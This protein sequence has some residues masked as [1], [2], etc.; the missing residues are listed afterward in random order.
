[1]RVQSEIAEM[2]GKRRFDAK[3]FEILALLARLPATLFSISIYNSLSS[4]TTSLDPGQ[5]VSQWH[6]IA[7][8]LALN[9][10]VQYT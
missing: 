9:Q 3:V 8:E 1:M 2:T 10:R 6:N 5:N 7:N 4:S